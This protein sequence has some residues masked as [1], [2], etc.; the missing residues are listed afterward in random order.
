MP[1]PQ[2]TPSR[3]VQAVKDEGRKMSQAA[4]ARRTDEAAAVPNRPLAR[5]VYHP[6]A[7]S[8]SL[9]ALKALVMELSGQVAELRKMQAL[10]RPELG[11]LCTPPTAMEAEIRRL[12]KVA[13]EIST[14]DDNIG[15]QEGVHTADEC[16][17]TYLGDWVDAAKSFLESSK[18]R[19]D[20]KEYNK[21]FSS[22]EAAAKRAEESIGS[23]REL[24]KR[25]GRTSEAGAEAVAKTPAGG[26][27]RKR[28]KRSK[29]KGK[30]RRRRSERGP[31]GTRS[32]R[33]SPRSI[34]RK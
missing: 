34:R 20:N 17:A 2:R 24:L 8:P 6:K 12:D 1:P 25:L 23:A 31:R 19:S 10:Q 7:L 3:Q 22:I 32:R 16:I 33:R 5:V 29:R 21:K 4:R 28:R 11:D 18:K 13:D 15:R 26:G 14:C 27:K 9:E 30:S